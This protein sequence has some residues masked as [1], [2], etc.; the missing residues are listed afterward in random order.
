LANRFAL[1]TVAKE[2]A[3]E[4]GDIILTC[5]AV[6]EMERNFQIDV[7]A[8]KSGAATAV[9]K[10]YSTFEARHRFLEQ[11][12]TLLDEA[13]ATEHLDTARKLADIALATA[14]TAND[15]GAIK[16]FTLRGG[17]IR[18]ADARVQEVQKALLVLGDKPTDADANLKVGKYRC[19]TKGDWD[20]GL[21]LLG[22]GNDP[23][24]KALA[25]RE[26]EGPKIADEQ[27]KL[28][29]GWFESAEKQSASA[30]YQIQ[31]HAAI[32]YTKAL[33][34]LSGLAKAKAEKRISELRG[35]AVLNDAIRHWL[36]LAH[37]PFDQRDF[38]A[39]INILSR[40]LADV[41]TKAGEVMGD[42]EALVTAKA[43][44]AKIN[45][46]RSMVS[47]LAQIA[48]AQAQ[49]GDEAGAEATFVQA[50]ET[51]ATIGIAGGQRASTLAE[52]AVARGRAG[53]TAGSGA[54]FV[55]ARDLV[56]ARKAATE[57]RFDSYSP[58]R[59]LVAI[60]EAQAKAGDVAGAKET[61][62]RLPEGLKV[63]VA[64]RIAEAQARVGDVTGAKSTAAGISENERSW[65]LSEIA[66]AEAK[67]GDT[68]GA[69]TT[70]AKITN[71]I[72]KA[73]A[74]R[75]VGEAQI[76]AADT[77]GAK[78]T[79]LLAKE[80]AAGVGDA[81]TKVAR[82]NS[83]A[84]PS[85]L[86][87]AQAFSEI[88]ETQIKAEDVAGAKVTLLLAKEAATGITDARSK[89]QVAIG[90]TGVLAKLGD[91]A[92]A[93]ETAA[94]ISDEMQR[95][96]ALIVIAE[97]QARCADIAGA[98][99]TVAGISIYRRA[100]DLSKIAEAQARSLAEKAD[101]AW[102]AALADQTSRAM[103]YV[104]VVRGLLPEP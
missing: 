72:W 70:A 64:C 79:L 11:L 3:I 25:E 96:T 54:T 16:Q 53:D 85:S 71:A 48:V 13:V 69:K 44:A 37:A 27:T 66:V 57:S 12:G 55:L 56:L 40:S 58:D 17:R 75:G 65:P 46:A 103:A 19:F 41:F 5:N 6:D 101:L 30:K 38:N 88:A 97:V 9:A 29:D 67:T 23:A 98:K 73:K 18:E 84:Q 95:A 36:T 31:R 21:P 8:A 7:P 42:K 89:A 47:A 99:E 51:T 104:G 52:V 49:V 63:D 68:Q 77:V 90:I 102:I 86:D 80:T 91:V 33:P 22:L 14:R 35:G 78:A 4:A 24:L 28:A 45:D 59:L 26:M 20:K 100:S 87:K 62:A 93:K 76:R 32:W 82:G 74:L 34:E 39:D 50:M 94:G 83:T 92:G 61:A 1:L 2:A 15:S 10:I 60:A 81:L 43:M